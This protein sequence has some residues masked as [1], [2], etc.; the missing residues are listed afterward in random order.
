MKYFKIFI[1]LFFLNLS[2]DIYFNN[3]KEF[4]ELRIF[5]KPL[6][7]II[8]GVFFYVSSRKMLLLH[9]VTISL[10]LMF[11]CAGD[12]VLL[13]NMSFYSF[14]AGLILFLIGILL[15][16]FY[17]Y[18]QTIY[19]I[20]RLIA[21]L[22]VSLLIALALIYL[23]YDG[24]NNLLIP[25]MIYLATVLNF[26]KIAFLRYKNVNTK[27]YRLVLIGAI[28]F[29]ITQAIIGLNQFHEA[30]PYKYIFVMLFYGCS[31]L[32]IISGILTLKKS[33]KKE[34]SISV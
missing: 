26:M 14:T 22:A 28:F 27:S 10:A 9:R 32:F 13:E 5:T 18:K 7:T 29:T 4:Y 33:E 25:V 12:I 1:F 6:I 23:M 8:L 16:S 34:L 3:V 11:L 30:L 20:D 2:L 31:Q 24:L 17:F 21:F 19:D 15:Y